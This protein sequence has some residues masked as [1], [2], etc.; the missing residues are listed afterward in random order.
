MPTALTIAGSD[1]T[2]GA[3]LQADLQVFATLGVHGTAVVSSLTVQ[4]SL[5]VHDARHVPAA[6][7]A[8]QL[9]TLLADLGIDAAKT[10]MLATAETVNV[11]ADAL[12]SVADLPLVIDPVLV[13]TSGREL[14]EPAGVEALRR[15]LL[16][17]ATL[18][19]PNIPEAE[20]L[21][22]L[23]IQSV[24]DMRRAGEL[25]LAMGADAALIKGGHLAGAPIDVLVDGNETVE[26]EGRRVE[27]DAPAHGTGCALS[28]AI[29]ALLA[30]GEALRD[31]VGGAKRYVEAGLGASRR[32][33]GGAPVIDYAEAARALRA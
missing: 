26:L 29:A 21:T 14:L 9:Q 20:A 12:H 28:S 7:V 10:G 13:S 33:G 27:L 5:R 23:T 22:G 24:D 11:V 25:L 15:R 18:I 32:I 1:P 8:A 6:T 2:G 31:A 3:G 16:P 19:T 4:D 17:R 30:R